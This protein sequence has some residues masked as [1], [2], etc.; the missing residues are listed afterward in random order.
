[1]ILGYVLAATAL[2]ALSFALVVVG[3]AFAFRT[4]RFPDLTGDGTYVLGAFV[5]GA[6]VLKGHPWVGLLLGTLAGAA[7]GA[8]TSLVSS[9]LRIHGLLAS[10]VVVLGLYSVNLRILGRPNAPIDPIDGVFTG[11]FAAGMA[12]AARDLVLCAVVGGCLVLAIGVTVAALRSRLGIALRA[13]WSNPDAAGDYG[14]EPVATQA[15]GLGLANGLIGLAGALMAQR[16]GFV[17]VRM[18]LGIVIAALAAILVG[19]AAFGRRRTT[20]RTLI[21]ATIGAIFYKIA[22]FAALKTPWVGATDVNLVTVAIVLLALLLGR[23]PRGAFQS[24]KEL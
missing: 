9:K 21:A 22:V 11:I 7:A 8:V 4:V 5:S 16:I 13:S 20:G 2:D 12:P 14:V 24:L 23:R 1:L 6:L 15:V 3:V 18:G 10:I 17:D 19:E